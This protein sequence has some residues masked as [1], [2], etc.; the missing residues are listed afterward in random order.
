MILD[1]ALPAGAL[2]SLE[3]ELLWCHCCKIAPEDPWSA[4]AALSD[5][6]VPATVHPGL[7]GQRRGLAGD[8][9]GRS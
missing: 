1:E 6:N 7:V 2:D 4:F 8:S 9:E 3:T 5:A